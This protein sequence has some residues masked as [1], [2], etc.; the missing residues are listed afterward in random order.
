MRKKLIVKPETRDKI[1]V[2]RNA[3][4]ARKRQ[5]LPPGAQVVIGP[6][7][8]DECGM[9]GHKEAQCPKLVNGQRPWM[10]Q[11]SRFAAL[12]PPLAH[13]KISADETVETTSK[14]KNSP[15]GSTLLG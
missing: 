15:K 13:R 1:S 14:L 6:R 2:A 9:K 10:P 5:G 11:G 8:C 7:H 3:Y 4:W 12:S